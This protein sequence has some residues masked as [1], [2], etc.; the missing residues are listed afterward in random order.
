MNPNSLANLKRGGKPG[1]KNKISVNVATDFSHL[2]T[3]NYDLFVEKMNALSPRDY[4]NAY[5][6]LAKMVLPKK[7]EAPVEP[8]EAPQWIIQLASEVEKP[9]EELQ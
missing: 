3:T 5:L 1:R 7:V 2:I 9:K 4:V 8:Y 6:N